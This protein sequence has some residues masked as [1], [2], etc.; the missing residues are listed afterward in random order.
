MGEGQAPYTFSPL[1]ISGFVV[2]Q[3]SWV[4]NQ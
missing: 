1:F 2:G 4:N 3:N